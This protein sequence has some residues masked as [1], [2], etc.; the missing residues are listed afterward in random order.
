[1][2]TIIR[3]ADLIDSV[4]AALQYISYYHPADFIAHLAR[5]YDQS[6]FSAVRIGQSSTS[7]DAVGVAHAVLASSERIGVV[8][9]V[10]PELTEP[11]AAARAVATLAAIHP[12]R[13]VLDALILIVQAVEKESPY[14]QPGP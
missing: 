3:Q 6:P 10:R 2:S 8:L 13:L 14:R 7:V 9:T 12:G 1:M 4:A 11:V 5:R